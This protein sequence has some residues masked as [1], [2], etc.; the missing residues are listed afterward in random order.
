MSYK[1]IDTTT[2]R[3]QLSLARIGS[4]FWTLL[5][6]GQRF[7]DPAFLL[8]SSIKCA[9]SHSEDFL[10]IYWQ[11]PSTFKIRISDMAASKDQPPPSTSK[12]CQA[13][14]GGDVAESAIDCKSQS[15]PLD[16]GLEAVF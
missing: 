2:Y 7:S 9:C 12:D 8:E 10:I 4:M 15:I 5:W 11:S 3:N 16:V 14:T 1:K 6:N 13:S